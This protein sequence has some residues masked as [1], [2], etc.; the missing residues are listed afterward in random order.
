MATRYGG[1]LL[2]LLFV[3]VDEPLGLFMEVSDLEAIVVL[4][5]DFNSDI[6]EFTIEEKL[7]TYT[8]C[9]YKSAW[10]IKHC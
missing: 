9:K 4:N 6:K 5:I 10:S 2:F 7:F 8:R 3:I 1:L